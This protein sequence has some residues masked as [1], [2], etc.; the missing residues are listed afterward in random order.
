[1]RKSWDEYF[2]DIA[3]IV[4]TRSTCLVDPVGAVITRDNRILST[5]YNGVPSGKSHCTDQ[6]FCYEGVKICSKSDKP[7]KAIH[8]ETNAIAYAARYGVSLDDAVI[9]IT[10]KPCIN[11]SKL[12][13]SSGIEQIVYLEQDKIIKIVSSTMYDSYFD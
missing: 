2:I 7:S 10:K 13:L 3:Q 4:A 11:C 9:Y 1:M 8:A 6:G 12:I 5:G